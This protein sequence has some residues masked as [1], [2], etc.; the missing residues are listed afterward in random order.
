MVVVVIVLIIVAIV[1]V[2]VLVVIKIS[3]QGGNIK[4]ALGTSSLI[5]HYEYAPTPPPYY[6]FT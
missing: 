1:I 2:I 4:Y 3:P 6:H 5:T